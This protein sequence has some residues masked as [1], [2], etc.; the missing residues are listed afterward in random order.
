MLVVSDTEKAF[1][2]PF[3]NYTRHGYVCVRYV[4][5]FGFIK[6]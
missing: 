4:C 5:S 2:L 6:D 3:E 1:Y